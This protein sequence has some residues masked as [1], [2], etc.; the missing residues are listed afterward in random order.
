MGQ[1]AL[2][3]ITSYGIISYGISALW[4]ADSG[5]P[6]LGGGRFREFGIWN[7]EYGLGWS[8]SIARSDLADGN[9]S[10]QVYPGAYSAFRYAGMFSLP[11]LRLS[12]S[13]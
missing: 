1:Q 6:M 10:T 3:Y 7:M 9:Y 4:N 8:Y 12:L 13:R 11:I 5:D 2:Q